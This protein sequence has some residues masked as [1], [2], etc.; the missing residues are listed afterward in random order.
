MEWP[1]YHF[2]IHEYHEYMDAINDYGGNRFS[3]TN[4]T[5]GHE[6]AAKQTTSMSLRRMAN[7]GVSGHFYSLNF[8][9]SGHFNSLN[10]GVSGY[11]NYLHFGISGH[12]DFFHKKI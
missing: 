6:S 10:F 3:N 5:N 12:F 7:F 9:I 4:V 1:Q 2:L 11:F 8:G